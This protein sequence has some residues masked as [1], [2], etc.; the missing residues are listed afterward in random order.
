MANLLN[1]VVAED[2]GGC[3]FAGAFRLWNIVRRAEREGLEADLRVAAGQG[4]RHDDDEIAFLRQQQRQ[5]RNA[6]E[7]RHFDIEHRN[8]RIDALDLVDGVTAS[9][10]RSRD[11]HIGFGTDPARDQ[12]SDDDG[13]VDHHYPQRLLPRRNRGRRTCQR[14][15]HCSPDPAESGTLEAKTPRAVQPPDR[16]G[17][18]QIRP[19][20]WNFAV[21]MSLSNGFMMYSLAP[22]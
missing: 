17:A 2:F 11:N 6:V 13:V 4:R 16:K 22:A 18:G 21:T 3:R 9:A 7:V 5:R 12:P 14:N 15:T 8:I 1:E 19:T 10:Q 20:S